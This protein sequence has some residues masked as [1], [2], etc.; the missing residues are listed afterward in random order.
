MFK[1]SVDTIIADRVRYKLLSSGK[2]RDLSTEKME[3]MFIVTG[4]LKPNRKSIKEVI[5]NNNKQRRF[6]SDEIERG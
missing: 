5:R 4:G 3:I 6:L 1:K 2:K